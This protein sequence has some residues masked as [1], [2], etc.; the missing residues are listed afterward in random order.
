[1]NLLDVLSSRV[2][3]AGRII[4][5]RPRVVLREE[6]QRSKCEETAIVYRGEHFALKLKADDHLRPLRGSRGADDG[7]RNLP[8]YVVF[9]EEEAKGRAPI[10]R[11]LL[12]ELKSSEAGKELALRQIQLGAP[13]T[14]YLL[15][16]LKVDHDHLR[17]IEVRQ[18]GLILSPDLPA[19]RPRTRRG[20][21]GYPSERDTKIKI[22]IYDAP[23]GED[24]HLD[25]FF[26]CPASL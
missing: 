25:Q 24:V 1:M 10:L 9:S 22:E 20:E 13:V 6:N 21:F 17:S 15:S 3:D 26:Y 4:Q 2:L 18:A 23:C 11:A 19:A 14:L 12:V 5:P 16:L 8:D 7:Y